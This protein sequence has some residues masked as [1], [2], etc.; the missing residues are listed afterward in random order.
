MPEVIEP[1]PQ[2]YRECLQVLRDGFATQVEAF[3]IT[4][5]NNPGY[6]TYWPEDHIAELVGR[7]L[8]LLAVED[9]GRIV[10]CCFVG[11]SRREEDVWTLRHLTVAPQARRHGFGVLLVA[12][13]AERASA[14]GARVVRIGIIAENAR[15][16]E[17]YHRLGFVTIDAGNRYGT[18]PFTVDH[19]DLALPAPAGLAR[20]QRH[21]SN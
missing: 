1:G 17:W 3:G 12:A 2:R 7:T 18:L 6:P 14:A 13:T 16:S 5:Q 21:P 15:L 4:P 11:A 10:G 9:E 8:T 19:L 20:A